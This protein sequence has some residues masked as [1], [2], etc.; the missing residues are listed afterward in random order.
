MGWLI[1][2]KKKDIKVTAPQPHNAGLGQANYS[3]PILPCLISPIT[4]M[5]FQF[6][7][8]AKLFLLPSKPWCPAHSL[9]PLVTNPPPALQAFPPSSTRASLSVLLR[10]FFII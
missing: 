9:D 10:Q 1:Q 2:K 7:R 5:Q 8:T 6:I 3:S 4:L